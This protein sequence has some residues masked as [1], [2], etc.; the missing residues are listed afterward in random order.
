LAYIIEYSESSAAHGP[1]GGVQEYFESGKTDAMKIEALLKKLGLSPKSN[2]LEFAAGFGRVTRHLTHCRLTA[3]DIH[4]EAVHFLS[5]DIRVKAIPSATDP[6]AFAPDERFDFIFVLS[7]FSHLPATLF[8]RWLARLALTLRPGGYLMFT[9]HG[10]FAA[11]K[12]QAFADALDEEMGFGFL[13]NTDQRDLAPEIYGASIATSKFVIENI[14]RCTD[15][16]IVSFSPGSWWA[17]Q[18]EW[19]I[20]SPLPVTE[21][22]S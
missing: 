22:D 13:A 4:G 9:T 1:A 16:R 20:R 14:Y 18:D 11:R 19:I 3:S 7:L 12:V 21:A 8:E 10:D 15:A 17:L 6:D 5:E 2:I